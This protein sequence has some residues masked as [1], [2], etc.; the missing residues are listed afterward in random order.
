MKQS[1]LLRK[2]RKSKF[3][4]VGVVMSI[5]LLLAVVVVPMLI[6][7]DPIKTDL[8]NVLKKPE[9]FA[10]G[11]DGHILGTDGVGRDILARLLYGGRTSLFIVFLG[12]ALPS[13]VG[14]VLGVAAGYY[15]GL[16]DTIVMRIVEIVLSLPQTILAIAIMAVLG[17]NTYNL[18]IVLLLTSWVGYC[19]MA[20]STVIKFR[21][22]EF[23]QASKLLGASDRSIMF[24]QILPNCFTPLI[25]SASQQAGRIILI[26]ASL[27]FLGCGVP[28]PEPTWGLMIA[29]GRTY[30]SY[31]PWT[32][33]IPGL[34]LMY[35][36]LSFSFLGDGIRDVL[37][38]KNK[39]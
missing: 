9:W 38:P 32:V 13:V 24:S 17:A 27:S 7:M 29:E 1:D 26:E 21:N 20:R 18:V 11:L 31:A 36:V 3:F 19:R 28:P 37:D 35:A 30:I 5:L 15:G 4:V 34:F 8:R 10:N 25:I 33:I 6:E 16:F 12:M 39:D 2:M 22:Q 14:I 23:V